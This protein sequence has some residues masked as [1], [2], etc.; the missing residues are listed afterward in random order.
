[1]VMTDEQREAFRRMDALAAEGDSP[2]YRE[3]FAAWAAAHG[4]NA[5]GTPLSPSIEPKEA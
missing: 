2:E 4:M 1:M 3:A 5:D